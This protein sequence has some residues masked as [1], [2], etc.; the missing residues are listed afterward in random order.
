MYLDHEAS[1]YYWSREPTALGR[2]VKATYF[3][4]NPILNTV[5]FDMIGFNVPNLDY[6]LSDYWHKK[7]RRLDY[8]KIQNVFKKQKFASITREDYYLKGTW[9]FNPIFEVY[10]H[11]CRPEMTCWIAKK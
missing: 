1:P 2:L 3:H 4:S 7:E 11:V 5:Y 10:K 9:I 8:K 6:T